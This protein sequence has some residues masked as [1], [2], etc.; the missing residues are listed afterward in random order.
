MR[1]RA[2]IVTL[3]ALCLGVLTACGNGQM[4]AS[5]E[6]M[7]YDQIKGSGLAVKC[8]QLPESAR[9]AIAIDPDQSYVITDLCLEPTEYLVKEE[10][11]SKRQAAEF[12]PSRLLTRSTYTLTSISGP[13]EVNEDRS[14]TFVEEDGM[15]SQPITVLLPGGEEVPFLFSVK[16]L[17]ATSQP[18]VTSVNTST[19]FEG[20]FRVPAYRTGGFLDPRGRGLSAGY[21]TAVGLPAS[22]D[23]EELERANI[24]R[25]VTGKG[26]IS[27]K[28]SKV[29]RSTNEI[30][31]VFESEQP[32]ATERGAKDPVDVKV[33]GL[34]YAR[35]EPGNA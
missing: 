15:D 17:V 21:D 28:V 23:A 2:L 13:L 3:L 19:D 9:D 30:A 20:E 35:L 18:D 27:L 11:A 8:P 14:L 1:Y 10:S 4:T 31:G 34:F 25:A 29:N 33:R 12:V 5:Q 22:G 16:E 26:E 24:K 32:S 7:T 6:L